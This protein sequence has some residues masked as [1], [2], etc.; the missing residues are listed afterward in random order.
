MLKQLTIQNYALISKLEIDF[1]RGMSVI[2]GETGAGKSII[3]GALS[4][5]LGQRADAKSIKQDED[6]CLIE[7]LFDISSYQLES[8]FTERDLEYDARNCLLRREIW[9]SGKS[10]AFINDVP[11]GLTDLKDLGAFLIDIHSQHQNL[12]LAD[13]KFQLQV[14]DV[15][16]NNQTLREAYKT[17]YQHFLSVRKQLQELMEKAHTHSSD[18]EYLRFQFQQLEEAKLQA[19]EQTGWE[20][21]A[22]ALSHVEE[23]KNGMFVIE[24]CLSSEDKGIIVSLKEA[25][26]AAQA[27]CKLYPAA[28]EI[29]ERLQTAYL[30]LK[31]M[32][33]DVANRQE[34]LEWDPERLLWINQRLDLLYS[35][36]Q[37]H[38]AASVE[39]LI[40][41]RENLK[42]QLAE[43]ENYDEAIAERRQEQE[44]AEKK[45]LDLAH[46]LTQTR[47]AAAIRL[48]QR[49]VEQVSLLGMPFMQFS[50]FLTA[51]NVPDA[52]GLDD[53]SFL[54]S[55]NRNVPV[56][57]V[58][59]TASGGEISR[60]MLGIKA[61]IAGILALPTII[62]DEIDTGVS[63]E[64]A[65]KMGKIMHGMGEIM[66]VIVI[67][68]LP[69]IA[70]RG[71]SHFF[72]YK[73]ESDATET[74]IRR[75]SPEERIKEIAQMLSGSELTDAAIANAKELLK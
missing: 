50:C 36:Q 3:I 29:A 10:R 33:L 5:I 39:A 60:L 58:A 35:L 75:L 73:K 23:I 66:Q 18:Q 59:Q 53:I 47:Q 1:P 67:T 8:F 32:L 62:F 7:G 30:D 45:V 11:V 57:P 55:A 12:L 43:I 26:N 21:E 54:F 71:D 22:N 41:L 34:K 19:G 28:G 14:V 61:L 4:L 46:K 27:I 74:H 70:A 9:R 38:R 40:A 15:I 6:K 56:Q 68:H 51:K 69:Q 37:K 20:N 44:A 2:T 13:N 31:D 16:A 24:H 25:L 42:N 65:D 17:A 72:V 49:L 48:E 52:T 64:V 63:G